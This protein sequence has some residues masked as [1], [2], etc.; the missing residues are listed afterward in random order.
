MADLI[1]TKA[2]FPKS[3]G[4]AVADGAVSVNAGNGLHVNPSTGMVEVPVDTAAGLGYG[5]NGL[6]AEVDGSTI[7]FNSTGQLTALGGGLTPFIID[8]VLETGIGS[9]IGKW[10]LYNPRCTSGLRRTAA[11]FAGDDWIYLIGI[12]LDK[13]SS[14]ITDS[15]LVNVFYDTDKTPYINGMQITE[16]EKTCVPLT[17]TASTGQTNSTLLKAKYT[18]YQAGL[19]LRCTGSLTN[20]APED[21]FRRYCLLNILITV[22]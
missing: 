3:G 8:N 16:T 22:K 2:T 7:D 19:I 1:A 18:G 9:K 11:G 6:E 21:D 5:G 15:A 14:N 12:T 13:T 4:L 10:T 20:S 17:Y